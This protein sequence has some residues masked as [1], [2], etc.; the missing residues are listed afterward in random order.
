MAVASSEAARARYSAFE[1]TDADYITLTPTRFL[2]PG[3]VDT[4]LQ[5]PQWPSLATGMEG[6]LREWCENYT[7]P[8]EASYH[9]TA[10]AH[11]VYGDVVQTTLRLGSTTVAYNSTIHLEATNVRADM[12]LRYGQR[13]VIG[14]VCMLVGSRRGYFIRVFSHG[15]D[16]TAC[17]ISWRAWAI[18]RRSTRTIADMLSVHRR[19]CARR[20]ATKIAR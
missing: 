8:I 17:L 14:K 7:D 4:H 6:N 12:C 10:K 13:A 16:H 11:R 19:T 5:P 1:F 2:I 18:C 9:D 20:L 3:F 15:A